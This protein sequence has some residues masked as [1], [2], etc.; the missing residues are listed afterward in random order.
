MH[1]LLALAR[2]VE[3]REP[4]RLVLIDGRLCRATG[5]ETAQRVTAQEWAGNPGIVVLTGGLSD[6]DLEGN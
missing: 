4:F 6:D 1:A 3:M 5:I 2:A